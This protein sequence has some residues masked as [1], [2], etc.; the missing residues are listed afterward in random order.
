[1]VVR[2]ELYKYF[3]SAGTECRI[4]EGEYFYVNEID[5]TKIYLVK[6]GVLWPRYLNECGKEI[7]FHALGAGEI[8]AF[9]SFEED[10]DFAINMYAYTD[11]ILIACEMKSLIPY[12][13]E[14]EELNMCIIDLLIHNSK[15]LARQLRS[16]TL[17]DSRKRLANFLFMVTGDEHSNKG[18]KNLT[19]RVTHEE[20]SIRLNLSRV[21]ITKLLNEFVEIGLIECGYGKIR[22]VNQQGLT[23]I[24]EGN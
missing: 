2:K 19:I 10:K 11:V 20:L 17:L 1:M 12:M 16:L 6:K 5:D 4:K 23:D 3:E 13:Q 14:D 8:I 18:N 15:K 7:S 22:V 21:T 24:F 9:K